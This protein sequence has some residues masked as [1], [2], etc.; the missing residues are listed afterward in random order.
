MKKKVLS[1]LLTLVL[2]AS[3]LPAGALAEGTAVPIAKAA[4]TFDDAVPGAWY[5]AGVQYA[6]QNGLMAG[7]SDKSFA[8]DAAMTRAARSVQAAAKTCGPPP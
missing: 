8:P 4:P 2:T 3:L 1:A 5:Y 7:E 6:V